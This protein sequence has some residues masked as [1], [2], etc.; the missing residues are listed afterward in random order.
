[1]ALLVAIV[2]TAAGLGTG[3]RHRKL[4]NRQVA[5]RVL[6]LGSLLIIMLIGRLLLRVLLSFR[7]SMLVDRSAAHQLLSLLLLL[8]LMLLLAV[9]FTRVAAARRLLHFMLPLPLAR[10]TVVAPRLLRPLLL[11]L[12][13]LLLTLLLLKTTVLLVCLLLL[14]LW[15]LRLLHR[16]VLL[17]VAAPPLLKIGDG[18][19]SAERRL[20]GILVSKV[21]GFLKVCIR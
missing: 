3:D 21:D 20:P 6:P 15:M 12:L 18:E 5:P 10:W 1:M 4:C 17:L 9:R 14:L 13:V 19:S 2:N 7:L 16:V 11:P 8:P